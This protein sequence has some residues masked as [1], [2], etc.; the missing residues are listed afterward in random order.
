MAGAL[1]KRAYGFLMAGALA[2]R[3]YGPVVRERPLPNGQARGSALT[4][5]AYRFSDGGRA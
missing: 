5:R 4:K 1:E 2:K 3:A